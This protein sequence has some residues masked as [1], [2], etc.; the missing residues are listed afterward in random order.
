MTNRDPYQE[1]EKLRKAIKEADYI[2]IPTKEVF[3]ITISIGVVNLQGLENE[4]QVLIL[5]DNALY[6][7]K[8][9]GRN[10]V[11]LA[12]PKENY[13]LKLTETNKTVRLVRKALKEDAFTLYAQPII[14]LKDNKVAYYELLLRLI[15]KNGR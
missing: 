12:N 8:Q 5:A 4:H 14:D 6:K 15:D 1:A 9:G 7:A 11:V 10:R 2:D 3:D 13:I